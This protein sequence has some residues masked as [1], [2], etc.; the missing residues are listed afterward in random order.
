M[1][2]INEVSKGAQFVIWG[3]LWCWE[4]LTS[5]QRNKDYRPTK[6]GEGE[7]YYLT[8]RLQTGE[9]QTSS[10]LQIVFISLTLVL[11]AFRKGKLI[12]PP[13]FPTSTL[14]DPWTHS[15]ICITCLAP[16]GIS[17]CD[18]VFTVR[19]WENCGGEWFVQ[20]NWW[21]MCFIRGLP[22]PHPD[23]PSGILCTSALVI[24]VWEIKVRTN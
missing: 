2:R 10:G 19:K 23:C 11:N 21:A 24:L 12:C 5:S 18:P 9:L 1:K 6:T 16:Q 20:G 8:Q 3:E 14:P 4:I 13:H 7:N 22:H 15:R 17:I